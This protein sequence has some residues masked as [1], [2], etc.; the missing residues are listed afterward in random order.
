MRNNI[1]ILKIKGSKLKE[2]AQHQLV[3]QHSAF[4]RV[5]RTASEIKRKSATVVETE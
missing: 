4:G 1:E 2:T 3:F 5:E